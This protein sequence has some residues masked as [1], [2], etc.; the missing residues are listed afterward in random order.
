[1]DNKIQKI[2]LLRSLV[3]GFFGGIIWGI[4]YLIMYLFNMVEID[5][6][7]ILNKWWDA[8]WLN[9]WYSHLIFLMLLSIF[10]IIIA[11][12]YFFTLKKSKSWVVGGVFG[13]AVLFIIY[14][15]LPMLTTGFNPFL[16]FETDTHIALACLFILYG[17][18]VGY[19][20]SY[21]YEHMKHEFKIDKQKEDFQI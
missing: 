16:K 18:F 2:V 7:S 13:L 14:Y 4:L 8:E 1:M 9:K 3:I 17:V 21:D 5:H 12:I 10:S 19:S 20:I 15:I 6:I 11:L